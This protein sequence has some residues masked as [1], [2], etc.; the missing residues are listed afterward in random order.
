[1]T[2]TK[3]QR[4]PNGL[5]LEGSPGKD[6]VRLVAEAAIRPDVQAA[7]TLRE[8]SRA[9]FSDLHLMALVDALSEHAKATTAGDLRRGETMLVVQAH[10]LDQLFNTLTRRALKGEGLPH[11]DSYLKLALRA[12]AQCRATWEALSAIRNPPV[13]GY[14]RQ[15]NIALAQGPQQVNNALFEPP[16]GKRNQPNELSGGLNELPP[17]IRAPTVEI[18]ADPPMAAVAAVHRSENRRR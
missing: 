7:L 6:S 18:R 15:A 8:Y 3:Q 9:P 13:V 2:A 10:V 17:Q 5:Y 14:A 16:P 1:M 12:Q 4:D 11:F